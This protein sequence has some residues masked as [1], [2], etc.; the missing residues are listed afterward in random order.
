M[1]LVLVTGSAG[2]IGQPVCAELQRRGYRALAFNTAKTDLSSLGA[3]R[4]ALPDSQRIYIGLEGLDGAG[5]DA[6]YGRE[7]IS[8]HAA[9]IRAA[10]A[11]AQAIHPSWAM[12]TL[13]VRE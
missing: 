11:S 1:A 8:A 10:A 4:L 5:S 2:A 13:P 12:S 7:C 6:E 9:E 3:G